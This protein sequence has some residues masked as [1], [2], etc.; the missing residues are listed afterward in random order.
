[1]SATLRCGLLAAGMHA[2]KVARSI[3]ESSSG[4]VLAV[5]SRSQEAAD[6]FG[7]AHDVPRRYESYE[8]LLDDDDVDVVYISTPHPMHAEWAIKAAEAGKHVLCEKPLTLN[9]VEA[10]AVVAAAR[11]HD[12]FLMEAFAYR[13]HPHTRRLVELV[14]SGAVG[15]VCLIEVTFSFDTSS[16][17]ETMSTLPRLTDHALGGGGILDVGCYCMSMA[18]MLAGAALGER[19][20]EPLAVCGAGY[21]DSEDRV[22]HYAVA[23]LEFP[24]GIVAQL[25][26]GVRLDQED[27]IRVY[28]QEGDLLVSQPLWLPPYPSGAETRDIVLRAGAGTEPTTISVRAEQGLFTL[29]ADAVARHLGDREVPEMRWDDSLGNMRALDRWREAVG[30]RYEMELVI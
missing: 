24:Q 11:R 22:D 1:M 15:R 12:V 2:E 3:A 9:E 25:S 18:R 5:G 4:S 17:E 10:I 30:M 27:S 7:R 14:R 21:V 8:A 16:F 19:V 20:V 28:G 23:T 29:Q 26:T 6:R 13:V